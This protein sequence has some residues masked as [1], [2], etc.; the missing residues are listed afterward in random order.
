MK[1]FRIVAAIAVLAGQAYAQTPELI[2]SFDSKTPQQKAD[3]ELR[4]KVAREK[5]APKKIPEADA[6]T[7][8]DPWGNVRSGA[9]AKT[10]TS[11]TATAKISTA[12]TSTAKTSTAKTSTSETSDSKTS[13]SKTSNSKTSNSKTATSVKPPTKPGT[14]AD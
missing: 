2:H 7:S 5:E 4:E 12:K 10:S 8:V 6:K 9:A 14:D 1:V 11:K 13:D 3:D